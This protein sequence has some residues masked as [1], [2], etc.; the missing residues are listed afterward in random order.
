VE[1]TKEIKTAVKTPT[2][3]MQL[4]ST[5]LPQLTKKPLFKAHPLLIYDHKT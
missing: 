3:T 5:E 2:K 4:S 1:E